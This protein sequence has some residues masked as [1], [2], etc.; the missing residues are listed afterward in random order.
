MRC[1]ESGRSRWFCWRCGELVGL[2]VP[3]SWGGPRACSTCM[4]QVG[5]RSRT[6]KLRDQSTTQASMQP[7][8]PSAHACDGW[9][10]IGRAIGTEGPR[11]L[12]CCFS[13]LNF[14]LYDTISHTNFSSCRQHARFG[15]YLHIF[16][17]NAVDVCIVCLQYS[18]RMK[19]PF[20]L[21]QLAN[22]LSSSVSS[23]DR[24][25]ASTPFS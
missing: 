11:R 18:P 6:G 5:R 3:G 19:N 8:T 15:D 13:L 2:H 10:K 12:A 14:V 17:T 22:D 9:M 21:F 1:T 4:T 20:E 25:L 7:R 16:L 24:L 23:F